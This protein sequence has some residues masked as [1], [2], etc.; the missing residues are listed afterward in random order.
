[1]LTEEDDVEIH[2]LARRDG[3]SYCTRGRLLLP[4]GMSEA[5]GCRSGRVL[6]Q[7]KTRRRTISARRA[8][9]RRDCRF[10]SRVT[11]RA[12]RRPGSGHLTLTV[13]FLGHHALEPPAACSATS[14]RAHRRSRG[15]SDATNA[16]DSPTWRTLTSSGLDDSDAAAS[17]VGEMTSPR[18]A[19][20]HAAARTARAEP[21]LDYRRE[22]V[23]WPSSRDTARARSARSWPNS[24]KS[25]RWSRATGAEML[26][27]ARASPAWSKIGAPTQ[28][29]PSSYSS[30]SI[31]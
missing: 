25:R 22:L 26:I 20:E 23:R 10:S 4:T 8:Q 13:R 5:E 6:V 27:A 15:P 30:L 21:R 2:A 7:V 29:T 24:A 9:V 18:R 17:G 31:A 28:P 3:R 1:M 12:R 11:F 19:N 16:R 14:S